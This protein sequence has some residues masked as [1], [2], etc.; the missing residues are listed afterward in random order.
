MKSLY[1]F[2]SYLILSVFI[3]ILL[4]IISSH[5]NAITFATASKDGNY[6]PT[7]QAI[8]KILAENGYKG[9]EVIESNGSIENIQKLIGR[10]ADLAIVQSDILFSAFHAEKGDPLYFIRDGVHELRG[11]LALY[12]EYVQIIVR[13]DSKINR[14]TRLFDKKIYMGKDNSGTYQ[15][16][17]D[18]LELYKIKD[19]DYTRAIP[20]CNL[21]Q[22]LDSLR[23]GTIDAVFVT[24]GE[25][26]INRPEL[27]NNDYQMVSLNREMGTTLCNQK[28]CY[29]LREIKDKKGRVVNVI[30]ARAVLV[31]RGSDPD[32]IN[33]LR[34]QDAN[35][36]AKTLYENQLELEKEVK[37]ELSFFRGKMMVRK[38]PFS[39][40]LGAEDYFVQKDVLV[41][42]TMF[43]FMILALGLVWIFVIIGHWGLKWKWIIWI[44]ESKAV[45]WL[46]DK[47]FIRNSWDFF[48]KVTTSSVVG[49]TSL[50]LLFSLMVVIRVILY[51]ERLYSIQYDSVNPF[52]EMG[53][54]DTLYWFMTFAFTGFPQ[55]AF[56][57][58]YP[59]KI[60]VA[61]IP[62]IGVGSA[63]FLIVYGSIKQ[64][65]RLDKEAKGLLVPKLKD[66]V[67]ICGWND[68]VP[69]LIWEIT[70]SDYFSSS[71][72]VVVLAEIDQ[73][74]PLEEYN[75]QSGEVYYYRGI[76]SDY[77]NLK[78]V[79]VAEAFC[80]VVVAGHKKIANRN[81]R[82]IFTTAALKHISQSYGNND[83]KIIAEVYYHKNSKFYVRTGAKKLVCLQSTS[84]RMM[85][86]AILNPGISDILLDFLS[87]DPPNTVYLLNIDDKMVKL[88]SGNLAGKT[89]EQ[90]LYALRKKDLLLL[91]IYQADKEAEHSP[92]ELEFKNSD[93]P[94]LLCPTGDEKITTIRKNDRLLLIQS[95]E[96]RYFERSA[97]V[98]GKVKS[99][100]AGD[101]A[102]HFNK[103]N[104]K[105]LIIGHEAICDK[106]MS[107]IA[108][109]CEKIVCISL[110]ERTDVKEN[111]KNILI[112]ANEFNDQV[113][114]ENRM[115]LEDITRAVILAPKLIGTTVQ[116]G[117][118]FDDHTM[119]LATNLLDIYKSM[120]NIDPLH[121]IAEL[122]NVKNLELFH[123]IGIAQAV[124][125]NQ[126]VQSILAQMVFHSGIVSEFF[127]KSM[128]YANTN[129][130]ACLE[131]LAVSK[132]S[133]EI[134]K[135]IRGYSY[136]TVIKELFQFN[137]QLLAI[138]KSDGRRIINPKYGNQD[139]NVEDDDF[140]YAFI[141]P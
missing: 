127:L 118:Y 28:P 74:K 16:A 90:A 97:S 131:K 34:K 106:V 84:I 91:A 57:N 94:Y 141:K 22:A 101:M 105:V 8:A 62:I 140:L 50:F 96:L 37:Q 99:F 85:T 71:K 30:F 134:Q 15:N 46:Y 43:D 138:E 21:T 44:R 83:L 133:E 112:S 100:A 33:G 70:S 52:A 18:I 121:I 58:S 60:A 4:S 12:P 41:R 6:Y 54:W 56:P 25:V 14:V 5:A 24:S 7:G 113:V 111:G 126:L 125:T 95:K 3:L 17:K 2:N 130:K 23:E 98:G 88:K 136:D 107:P 78:E 48:I 87:F 115:H 72:K 116:Q 132:L 137:I 67:V 20:E 27:L 77:D 13:S 61:I 123:D 40:H 64:N 69:A 93:S 104:E 45:Q 117:I 49:A 55:G 129:K 63:I 86:H 51:F 128:S 29:T 10:N 124:P 35:M 114:E 38:I 82:S 1:R 108:N 36:I 79:N 73:E 9:V 11:L 31:A 102:T 42:T 26:I 47:T 53:F 119:M 81:M 120:F 39:I 59:G 89:F 122:R 65:N 76:S 32:I 66:H 103:H 19:V 92:M 135:Q 80:C 75:F 68:R 110:G 109:Y 139:I